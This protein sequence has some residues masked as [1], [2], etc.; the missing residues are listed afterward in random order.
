MTSQQPLIVVAERDALPARPG[1]EL[2][3]DG[4]G[5]AYGIRVREGAPMTATLAGL[6]NDVLQRRVESGRSTSPADRC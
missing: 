5:R 3:I 2:L 6:I 4:Q 1:V